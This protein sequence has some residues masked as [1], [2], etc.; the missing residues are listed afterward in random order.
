MIRPEDLDHEIRRQRDER[1]QELTPNR[2]PERGP[3]ERPQFYIVGGQPGAGK[4]T[5]QERLFKTLPAGSVASY[6]GDDNAK[7][8]P[9]YEKIMQ[10][11]GRGGQEAVSAELNNRGHSYHSEY[12]GRLRGEYGGP[13]YDVI[14]SHPLGKQEHADAWVD[15]FRDQGYETTAVFVA[16]HESNSRLGIAHRYQES[17]DDPDTAY[18]RWLDPALHDNFYRD[19]PDVAHDLESQAKVDHL[20]VVNRDG[21]VL[22]ENHRDPDGTMVNDLGARNAITDERSRA[23]TP[24]EESRFE[25]TVA[26]MRSTDPNIRLE[27]VDRET[28]A[29][30][31][32]AV[33]QREQLRNSVAGATPSASAPQVSIDD[34][35]INQR[36]S[37]NAAQAGESTATRGTSAATPPFLA[38]QT[39][40]TSGNARANATSGDHGS[41]F[42]SRPRT[43]GDAASSSNSAGPRKSR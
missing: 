12:M 33:E 31:D 14:A 4:S 36:R 19:G 43:H 9:R 41:P 5:T 29:T 10:V 30:V 2:V 38:G 27:P 8:H 18:G 39:R 26:Y 6:D 40:S 3:G 7:I 37:T 42:T 16:T 22:H 34:A 28:L 32:D 23:P 15:D 25:A 11:Y 35:I 21:Q 20:F 1:I 13:K 17:R 24:D